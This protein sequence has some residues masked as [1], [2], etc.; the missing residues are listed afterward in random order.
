MALISRPLSPPKKSIRPNNCLSIVSQDGCIS[1][2]AKEFDFTAVMLTAQGLEILISNRSPEDLPG[3]TPDPT[4][5]CV[6][7]AV[8]QNSAN[9]TRHR[10]D[11]QEMGRV[12]Y[13]VLISPRTQPQNKPVAFSAL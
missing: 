5:W 4:K 9:S 1:L 11:R 12:V 2:I 13:S 8:A 7:I 6:G 3:H 10:R